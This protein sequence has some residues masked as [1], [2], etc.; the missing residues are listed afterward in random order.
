MFHNSFMPGDGVNCFDHSCISMSEQVSYLRGG[1]IRF[2]ELGAVG[3]A[4]VMIIIKFIYSK[5]FES[6]PVSPAER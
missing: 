1:K 6:F 4:P 5:S 2:L 3:G